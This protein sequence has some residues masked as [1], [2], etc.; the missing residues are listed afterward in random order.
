MVPVTPYMMPMPYRKI[1]EENA[2]SRMYF[3]PASLERRSNLAY[4]G[5]DVQREAQQLQRDVG[6][7]QLAG[8]RHAVRADDAEQDQRVVLAGVQQLLLH[9][10]RG[11]DAGEAADQR[12]EDAEE[13]R[14]VVDVDQ[15]AEVFVSSTQISETPAATNAPSGSEVA[16]RLLAERP[17]KRSSED[18]RAPPSRRG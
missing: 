4:D 2:P 10:A 14:V 17:Q 15:A 5:E 9:V 3:R 7:Q 11:G 18:D 12:E 13:R 6:R 1:A 16:E 8:R